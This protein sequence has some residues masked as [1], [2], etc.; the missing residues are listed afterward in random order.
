VPEKYRDGC[1]QPTI[2]LSTRF[3]MKE[4]EKRQKELKELAAP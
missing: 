2:G 3:P 4:L 1:M